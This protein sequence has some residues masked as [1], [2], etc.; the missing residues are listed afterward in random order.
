LATPR[1]FSSTNQR[2]VCWAAGTWSGDAVVLVPNRGSDVLYADVVHGGD[3][4]AGFA[5]SDELGDRL[6]ADTAGQG[7][8]TEAVV[9]VEDDG[10]AATEGIEAAG[11]AGAVVVEVDLLQEGCGGV[12]ELQRSVAAEDDDVE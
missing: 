1:L 12:G 4:F 5:G 8:F 10:D 7:G 3:P 2:G 6:C 11:V 9:G